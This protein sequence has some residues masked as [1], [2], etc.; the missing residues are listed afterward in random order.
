MTSVRDGRCLFGWQRHHLVPGGPQLAQVP[1]DTAGFQWGGKD[2]RRCCQI[3]APPPNR[4]SHNKV[5][6][7]TQSYEYYLWIYGFGSTYEQLFPGS[8]PHTAETLATATQYVQQLKAN[9]GGTKIYPVWEQTIQQVSHWS[10][11]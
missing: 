9:L 7:G 4:A 2:N 1:E 10:R 3:I 8:Q 5:Y 6:S 11:S